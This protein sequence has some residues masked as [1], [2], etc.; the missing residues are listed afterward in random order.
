MPGC[1]EW[2]AQASRDQ[3]HDRSEYSDHVGGLS[4]LRRMPLAPM[5]GWEMLALS[6]TRGE[7]GLS[8]ICVEVMAV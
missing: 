4:R 7:S 2:T 8:F 1:K 3:D 6:E 5:S